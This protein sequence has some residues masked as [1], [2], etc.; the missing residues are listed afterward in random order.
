[1]KRK[2]LFQVLA[3]LLILALVLPLAACNAKTVN[4]ADPLDEGEMEYVF[5]KSETYLNGRDIEGQWG[6][7]MYT[8]SGQ[9]GIGD[10]FVL[11]Y[12][13]KYYMYPSSDWGVGEEEGIKVFSSED[14]VNWTYEGFAVQGEEVDSAY[15]PE[16]VYYNGWFYLCESQAGRG[17]YIFRSQSPIGPFERI[18]DNFGRNIDGAFWIGDDGELF[19]LYPTGNTIQIAP[20]DQET[21]LPGIETGLTGTINGW[22]EGPGLF[23]RGD[24]LYMTY[25]GNSVVSDAYRV[26]YSYQLGTDPQGQFIMPDNNLLL[27]CTDADGFRG[28]GHNSNVI[29][30]D[31]DSWYTA[32]HNL[33][34]QAGPQRRYMVDKL[35]TSG[36]L[37]TANGPSN[38]G[39]A[40]PERPDFETRGTDALL[41]EGNWLLSEK[42]SEAVYTA[43]FNFTPAQGGTVSMVFG[44]ED[45]KN[46]MRA[47]WDDISKTLTLTAVSGGKEELLGSKT[48]DFLSAGVVH[49]LRVEQ[50]ASR[51]KAYMDTMCKLDL[52]CSGTTGKIGVAGDAQW[53]YLAFSNDVFGTSDF[54]TVKLVPGTFPAVCYLKGENR[55]FSIS[56]ASVRAEGIRQGEKENTYLETGSNAFALVLDTAGDWVKYAIQV[57]EDGFHGLSARISTASTGARFQIIVDSSEIYTF[58]VPSAGLTDEFVNLMLGQFPLT[59]GNHTLKIRLLQG[60]MEMTQF[61]LE[62]TNPTELSYE[63]ALDE[64]NEKGWSYIGNWKIIDGAHVARSGDTA[65]AYAGDARMT[66]FTVEVEVAM[67]EEATIFDAG[68]LLRA[69]DHVLGGGVDESF[70]GYYLSIRND[71]ITLNRYN[72]G[73]NTLDLIGVQ[74]QKNEFHRIKATVENNHILIYVDDMDTPVIDYYDSSA[75]LTGQIALCSNKAGCAFKNIK[76]NTL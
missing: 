51:L 10:P 65:Y 32:Y 20:V 15:A 69:Q 44:Y 73:S 46:H 4:Y 58:T 14:L 76:I 60:K 35:L 71:Q 43:E 72:Y 56:N 39:S 48:V 1:M 37:V 8:G 23:R 74:W 7:G 47:T 19:F 55:G 9:Y 41:E 29:G 31:L 66:D 52:T 30:P 70:R 24:Y 2:H 54:E 53:G 61:L 36:A 49:T 68:L 13:G 59:E 16:V 50:G 6:S 45:E 34:A 21:M 11:R 27:L 5:S 67:T 63:N 18:T 3:V 12:D 38:N 40:I 33:V 75:F 57:T 22:T 26:G 62:P 17:H 64:I 25:S 28:L 42:C